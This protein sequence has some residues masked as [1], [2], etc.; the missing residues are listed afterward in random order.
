MKTAVILVVLSNTVI[1][2]R[3]ASVVGLSDLCCFPTAAHEV[4]QGSIPRSLVAKTRTDFLQKGM[5]F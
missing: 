4:L 2:S 5:A 1:A 3:I